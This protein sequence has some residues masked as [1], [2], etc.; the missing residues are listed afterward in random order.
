MARGRVPRTA[1]RHRFRFRAGRLSLDF[2]GTVLW[3][4]VEPTEL[5]RRPDD[6]T[7]WLAA[8]GLVGADVTAAPD[9]LSPATE[10]REAVY[11]LVLARVRRTAWAPSDLRVL[12]AAA[13]FSP[14]VPSLLPDGAVSWDSPAAVRA[15]LAVLARDAIDLLAF[16]P[17]SRL[18]EC[19]ADDCAFLF[20]DTSRTGGR[21]WCAMDRCGNRQHVRAFRRRRQAVAR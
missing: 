14:A 2:T 8:V 3:R 6:L 9:D 11:R 13:S 15:A 20:L 16:A 17:A 21:R 18:R 5:L 7:R 4:R 1:D 12:N 10:L 19:A